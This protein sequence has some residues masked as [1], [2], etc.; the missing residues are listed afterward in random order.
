[1]RCYI[2]NSLHR[3]VRRLYHLLNRREEDS[4]LP[5][6][7]REAELWRKKGL[8]IGENTHLVGQVTFGRG[9]KDPIV[10]GSNCVLVNC[11][12][13]GH[14]ACTNRILGISSSPAIPVIIE[15]DCFI[16]HGAIILMGVR[17]G[18]G[19]IVGAGSVVTS[20]VL[21]GTVVAGNPAR[22]ICTVDELVERRKKMALQHPEYFPDL[23]IQV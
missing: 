19:A 7:L 18:R 12:I 20:D 14:D 8:S 2:S 15:D 3:F 16:G 21:A 4:S 13:L 22:M 9:G 17:V 1:M 10:I 5:K 11:A 6:S 23:P